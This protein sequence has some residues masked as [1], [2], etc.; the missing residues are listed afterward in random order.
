MKL[1][2]FCAEGIE[3]ESIE[4]IA[5]VVS[6]IF[7]VSSFL[8]PRHISGGITIDE[9]IRL[10]DEY[11]E[12]NHPII[13]ICY[14]QQEIVSD[15]I[16]GLASEQGRVALVRFGEMR[17]T[18]ITTLHEFGHVCDC[19]HCADKNC[20]MFP[21]YRERDLPTCLEEAFC[22]RCKIRL[23][24]SWPYNRV[25][26][27]EDER[28]N[29][30]REPTRIMTDQSDAFPDYPLSSADTEETARFVLTVFEYY[31]VDSDA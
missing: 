14:V 4:P 2:F 22:D 16:L 26:K 28:E 13:G 7:E 6:N 27:S 3:L 15:S 5:D 17:R 31:G 10:R 1:T 24:N 18:I 25:K 9:L 29:V 19:G 11:L 8:V 21:Y 30:R 23:L 12:S 20:V